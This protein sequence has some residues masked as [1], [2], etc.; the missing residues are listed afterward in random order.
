MQYTMD[1]DEFRGFDGW[2]SCKVEVWDPR[3]QV[4]LDESGRRCLWT[5]EEGLILARF[6]IKYLADATVE[7]AFDD[8]DIYYLDVCRITEEFKGEDM[9]SVF[10]KSVEKYDIRNKKARENLLAEWKA[11]HLEIDAEFLN[12]G[13]EFMKWLTEDP[14]HEWCENWRD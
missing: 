13:E 1:F 4:V 9:L 11:G 14:Q 10:L 8:D 12:G 5:P 6:E 2:V 7:W 3:E